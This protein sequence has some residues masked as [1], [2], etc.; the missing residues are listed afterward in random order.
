MANV[1]VTTPNCQ[2]TETLLT[3]G[4]NICWHIAPWVEPIPPSEETGWRAGSAGL[5]GRGVKHCPLLQTRWPGFP[6]ASPRR[7]LKNNWSGGQWRTLAEAAPSWAGTQPVAISRY[8]SNL[9][10]M[11]HRATGKLHFFH[12]LFVVK[13]HIFLLKGTPQ[14]A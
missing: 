4:E 9:L 14:L 1:A 10:Y 11:Y 8:K 13:Y 3:R 7:R 5:L 2:G 6:I 12:F